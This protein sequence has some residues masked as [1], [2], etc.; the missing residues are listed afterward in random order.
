MGSQSP[1]HL[2]RYAPS[3]ALENVLASYPGKAISQFILSSKQS[4]TIRKAPL[5]FIT[6]SKSLAYL[7]K[8]GITQ[9]FLTTVDPYNTA[10]ASRK[11]MCSLVRL[12]Q[13]RCSRQ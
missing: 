11:T 5:C 8:Q 9:P 12:L 13:Q 10:R 3:E 2:I 7:L 1:K 6:V 4:S